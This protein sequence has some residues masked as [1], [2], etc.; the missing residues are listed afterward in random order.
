MLLDR[1]RL[2][3]HDIAVQHRVIARD[4]GD[5]GKMARGRAVKLHVPPRA[6]GI[7]LRRREHPDRRLELVG[8]R[9]LRELLQ[10]RTDA[11]AG[12]TGAADGNQHVPADARRHRHRRRLDRRHAGGATHRNEGRQSE[13]GQAEIG[14]KVF[15]D[16][17]AREIGD[18]AVDVARAETRIGDR[19]QARLELQGETRLGRAPRIG[20]FADAAYRGLVAKLMSHACFLRLLPDYK[21]RAAWCNMRSD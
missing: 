10:A 3:H 6:L 5:L 1:E 8:Q 9:E 15:R 21:C 14:D 12:V 13:I 2:V 18:R 19:G 20:R 11:R 4:D 16:A 17:A 7:E